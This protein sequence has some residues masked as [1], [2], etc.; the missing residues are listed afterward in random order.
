M[1]QILDK[2]VTEKATHNGGNNYL[3]YGCSSMQGYR[4]SMEDRHNYIADI[5]KDI[6]DAPVEIKNLVKGDLGLSYFAVYDGHSGTT[7]EYFY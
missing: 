7:R 3:I 2:P 6:K 5:H 4:I 1:G